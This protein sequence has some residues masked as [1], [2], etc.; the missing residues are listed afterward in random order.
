MPGL[1]R[2]PGSGRDRLLLL[3]AAFFAVAAMPLSGALRKSATKC[4]LSTDCSQ[5]GTLV[6]DTSQPAGYCTQLN[7]TQRLVPERCGV[8]RVP[9]E[10]AGVRIQRL[11]VAVANGPDLLHG[12]LQRGLGLPPERGL[13]VRPAD[14]C[15]P[16]TPRF[17]TTTRRSAS[18]SSLRACSTTLR[19]LRTQRSA[20][21]S[22]RAMRVRA[23]A[24]R[25]P[26]DA[27]EAG[28]EGGT[29][30]GADAADAADGAEPTVG[31]TLDRRRRSTRRSMRPST[32]PQTAA[33]PMRRVVAS[34][35]RDC[36]VCRVLRALAARTIEAVARRPR[37]GLSRLLRAAAP[38]RRPGAPRPRRRGERGRPRARARDAPP[39]RAAR[40]PVR[41]LPA[42]P[43]DPRSRRFAPPPG[44]ARHGTRG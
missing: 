19:R 25:G 28:G 41:A 16:G 2:L 36:R 44:D 37:A 38:A 7:C 32:R 15:P 42:R 23:G 26:V 6:C 1:I 24:R 13:H 35:G 17:S 40:G 31:S 11:P 20:C 21:R 27:A 18:A 33:R 3:G 34:L 22:T 9:V 29:D 39:R 5:Q 12:A 14:A 4:V 30:A 10:R 8:R 43:G